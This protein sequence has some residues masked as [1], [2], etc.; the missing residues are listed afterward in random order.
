MEPQA[1]KN[2]A[3][4]TIDFACHGH[5]GKP[6]VYTLPDQLIRMDPSSKYWQQAVANTTKQVADAGTDGVYLDQTA[7]YYASMC[8]QSSG[9]GSRWAD[10]NRSNGSSG[11]GS[12]WADGNRAIFEASVKA[13]GPQKAIISESNAEAYMG[14]LHAYLAIYGF[15]QCGVVPGFQAVYGGW[16]IRVGAKDWP[17]DQPSIRMLLAQQWTYGH[18]MGRADP[19]TFLN[20]NHTLS[21]T[22]Q[23]AQLKVNHSEYLVYGR[24]MHPLVLTN[25]TGGP[26]RI[27]RWAVGYPAGK[28]CDSPVALAQVW[29][30][31]DGSLGLTLANPSNESQYVRAAL[32]VDGHTHLAPGAQASV[33]GVRAQAGQTH[34]SVTKTMPP[35]SAAIVRISHVV[36]HR[37][38]KTDDF[39]RWPAGSGFVHFN[40]VTA[41]LVGLEHPHEDPW[42]EQVEQPISLVSPGCLI[43]AVRLWPA[44]N[45]PLGNASKPGD[46]WEVSESVAIPDAQ[47]QLSN[48]TTD[49]QF[50]YTDNATGLVATLSAVAVNGSPLKLLMS[51]H[52]TGHEVAFV[53][54]LIF[55]RL[56]GL[57]AP[58]RA[59]LVSSGGPRGTGLR[60]TDP[61][62]NINDPQL[63]WFEYGY[64]PYLNSDSYPHS[65]MNWLA[66]SSPAEALYIGV[67]DPVLRVTALRAKSHV[68]NSSIRLAF[69]ANATVPLP[70]HATSPGQHYIRPAVLS[71]V[72]S[73][74]N[75]SYAQWHQ[76]A[77]IYRQ[78]LESAL[79]PV[80]SPR[81][82][83][84]LR[85][86]FTGLDLSGDF[87]QQFYGERETEIDA[88]W[89]YGLE[90]LNLWGHASNPQC[91]PG[92][93]CPDPGRGGGEGFK[94][95]VTRLQSSGIRVGTYFEA[96]CA[97]PVF[98]N[99]TS[100]RGQQVDTLPPAQRPPQL[101]EMMTHAAMLA[102]AW[103]HNHNGNLQPGPTGRWGMLPG[104]YERLVTQIDEQTGGFEDVG[105]YVANSANG[106]DTHYLLSMH[107]SADGWFQDYLGGWLVGTHTSLQQ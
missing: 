10:G 19:K 105:A 20:N 77:K 2:I 30:A 49:R 24:L 27:M 22:R 55:P 88:P 42:Q 3:D 51:L 74:E 97:N 31:S 58:S 32:R 76:A 79:V 60:T 78:W 15:E 73:A 1:A 28:S 13:A 70:P 89:F 46:G 14:S 8:F 37:A 48:S 96:E 106:S 21:F 69:A 92:F 17:T 26:L 107:Y 40:P 99:A 98:S 87:P 34:L 54:E 4:H 44:E 53:A 12:R 33:D 66:L 84:W 93:P 11:G 63:Q 103:A 47:W 95:Y 83:D 90:I 57:V 81:H 29:M 56:C 101:E 68:A 82:P 18:V 86:G 9:S 6:L 64:D 104:N 23:L 16:S 80:S 59:E 41:S 67:H 35:L 52:N 36:P 75:S 91:C 71:F 94:A 7:S 65:M 85:Q 39:T 61:I 102:P 43:F 25:T 72:R 50:V 5:D 45:Q 100:F 38:I 62:H